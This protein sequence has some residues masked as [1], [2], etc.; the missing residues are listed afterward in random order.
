MWRQDMDNIET[1]Q[2]KTDSVAIRGEMGSTEVLLKH[3]CNG[4]GYLAAL[5]GF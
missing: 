1:R 5:S 3:I 4:K 2:R